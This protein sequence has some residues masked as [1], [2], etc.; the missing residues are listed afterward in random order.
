MFAILIS[1]ENL[2]R[3]AEH[4]ETLDPSLAHFIEKPY[5]SSRVNWY[6]IRGYVSEVGKPESW[7]ALPEHYLIRGYEFDAE[8]VKTDWDQIVRKETLDTGRRWDL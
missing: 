5:L 8:A 6:Y 4:Q 1:E 3:I 7:A 2:P